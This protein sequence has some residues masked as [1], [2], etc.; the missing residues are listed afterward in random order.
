MNFTAAK[1][2]GELRRASLP[3]ERLNMARSLMRPRLLD[4][5]LVSAADFN[6]GYAHGLTGEKWQ[7]TETELLDPGRQV[8]SL[9]YMLGFRAGELERRGGASNATGLAGRQEED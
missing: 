4:A 9:S 3:S 6:D 7:L 1:R 8:S 2:A 5:G